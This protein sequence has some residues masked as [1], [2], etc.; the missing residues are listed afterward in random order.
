M[1][2]S[3]GEA[4]DN[5]LTL[6]NTPGRFDNVLSL[7]NTPGRFKATSN[8]E[9][10]CI[11][12]HEEHKDL[13]EEKKV[14]NF[15]AFTSSFLGVTELVLSGPKEGAFSY[16][17]RPAEHTDPKYDGTIAEF[18][19]EKSGEF[20][21]QF[22]KMLRE[23]LQNKVRLC[24]ACDKSNA[25]T[26]LECNA[27]NYSL[28]KVDI[29]FTD[30]IFTGFIFGIAKTS[31]PLIISMR[32]QD[33]KVMVIDDLLQVTPVHLDCIYSEMYLSDLRCLFVNPREALAVL[34]NMFNKVWEVIQEQFLE[35]K[36]FREKMLPR[37]IGLSKADMRKHLAC[38]LNFPPSQY[39]LHLQVMLPPF[40]PFH[41]QMYRDGKHF[42][43]WRFFPFEYLRDTLKALRGR[44]IRSAPS[45][46]IFELV[47][48]IRSKT[49][50][51]YE[52]VYAHC[53]NRYGESHKQLASWRSE[54][55]EQVIVDGTSI[56]GMED[57]S[58]YKSQDVAAARKHD[59][60][61]LQ[62]YG[63]PYVNGAPSGTFY[64]YPKNPPLRYWL[65]S[66]R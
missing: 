2:S 24:P 5:F 56:L 44:P 43:M 59:T 57:M 41:W 28:R 49:G 63:R 61:M 40:M 20:R 52:D 13:Y 7:E 46:D 22:R 50:I 14:D 39:Q 30:N 54:D 38:G 45:M 55:F 35:N 62:N 25:Y 17:N 53:Y 4:K 8:S 42:T 19:K 18:L 31:F 58:L 26:L 12:L 1:K 15:K 37:S 21:G 32:Y 3:V 48:V 16:V 33:R 29:T 6:E 34:Q 64:K 51:R 66:V 47:D 11:V 36:P 23:Q 10:S 27:C 65:E 9:A 60:R